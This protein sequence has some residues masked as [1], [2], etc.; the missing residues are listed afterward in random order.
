VR[1][2]FACG[3]KPVS[4]DPL[5]A[6]K[7]IDLE[8]RI[9]HEL[10][11]FASDEQREAFRRFLVSPVQSIQSWQYGPQSH[12]CTIVASDGATQIV[13]CPTGFGPSFPWSAQRVGETDLG[14]DDYWDAYLY[15]AFVCSRLWPHGAPKG[16]I[17]LALGDR[18]A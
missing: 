13:Y 15:E 4:L 16:L 8:Q 9:E 2:Y 5:G 3:S 14:R 17:H 7:M 6:P 10:S 1:Y 12:P 18:R 11:F